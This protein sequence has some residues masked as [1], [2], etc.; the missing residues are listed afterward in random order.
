MRTPVLLLAAVVL[1][2]C[3]AAAEGCE[4]EPAGGCSALMLLIALNCGLPVP[5]P[6]ISNTVQRLPGWFGT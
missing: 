6:V 3:G 2:A 5:R 4:A 1:G